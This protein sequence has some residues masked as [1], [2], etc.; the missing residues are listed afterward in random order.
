VALSQSLP[1]PCLLKCHLTC[2]ANTRPLAG[3]NRPLAT[4]L[5]AATAVDDC[6]VVARLMRDHE[7]RGF[8]VK[9]R[10]VAGLLLPWRAPRVVTWWGVAIAQLTGR[11]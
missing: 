2:P 9:T 3:G 6:A 5:F 1:V 10:L 8:N 4:T 7:S 11:W